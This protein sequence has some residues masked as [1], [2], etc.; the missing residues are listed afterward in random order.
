MHLRWSALACLAAAIVALVAASPGSAKEGVKATLRTHVPVDARA[1][2]KLRVAWTLAYRDEQGRR[3]PFDGE[4]IFVRLLSAS[5]ASAKIAFAHGTTGRYAATVRV[6]TG[7][8][9]AIQIGIR[10]WSSG[11]GGTHR[12]DALFPIT[13]DPFRRSVGRQP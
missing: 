3:H 1:G 9:R 11:A 7:G 12:S 6:P 10:G 5:G 2:A 8:M 4:G 13:N